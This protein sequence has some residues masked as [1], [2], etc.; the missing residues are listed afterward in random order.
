MTRL[1]SG[2]S[3]PSIDPSSTSYAVV[4]KRGAGGSF[5][6]S[7][8]ADFLRESAQH[9]PGLAQALPA[10]RMDEIAGGWRE[11]AALL[12]RQSERE[13]CDPALFE[14]ASI[15][16]AGLAD[17]ECAFFEEALRFCESRA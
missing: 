12:K 9:V 10:S 17:A 7:L 3:S 4:I 15:L 1:C 2:L 6:R 14:Q 11:V 13:P 8:Y 5:F 16:V